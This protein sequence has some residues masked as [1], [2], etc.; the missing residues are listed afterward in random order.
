MMKKLFKEIG[1]L[2]ISTLLVALAYMISGAIFGIWINDL[3]MLVL[4]SLAFY[5]IIGF[6]RLLNYLARKSR[7]ES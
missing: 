7:N 3:K 2:L 6:Y 4:L 5:F 1:Y